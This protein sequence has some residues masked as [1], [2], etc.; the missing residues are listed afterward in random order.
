MGFTDRGFYKKQGT[1]GTEENA[2]YATQ[3]I[4]NP[5]LNT[6]SPQKDGAY[7]TKRQMKD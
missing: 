1:N 2:A 7:Q 6:I 4:S 3:K 5:N